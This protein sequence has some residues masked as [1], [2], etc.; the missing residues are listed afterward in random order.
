MTTI[1]IAQVL[2]LA[3]H[4]NDTYKSA[5]ADAGAS[6]ILAKHGV[7][8]SPLRI[9][10]FF[11][12]ILEETGDF[13]ALVE[14]LNY[15]VEGLMKTWPS[16]FPTAESAA[17]FAHKPEAI[18]NKV[19][20]DRAELGNDAPG[21]G[22]RYRGRGLLQITG[23]EA[24]RR[25][26]GKIG[27]DLVDNPD[28]AADPAHCLEIAAAEYATAGRMRNGVFM[29]CNDF[30]D[31]DEIETITRIVNGGLI[32]LAQRKQELVRCKAV[33]LPAAPQAEAVHSYMQRAAPAVAAA[34]RPY[35]KLRHEV[36]VSSR[37]SAARGARR[38]WDLADLCKAYAWPSGA[39]GAG[40]IAIVE[41]AGGYVDED[42]FAFCDGA[43]VPRPNIESVAVH[44]G[45]GNNPGLARGQ[46]DD[47]DIEV[48]MDIEVA[49]AAYSFATGQP[50]QIR[51]YWALNRPGGIADAVRK[52]TADGCDVCSI[53]W[54]ADEAIWRSWA[55]DGGTQYVDDMEQAAAAAVKA[56]MIVFAAAGD[57]NASDGGANRANA[58]LP[59]SSPSVVG[60][61]GTTKTA[62]N[63]VVWNNTPGN[64][65]GEGTGG[66]FSD[67]FPRP[68]W[69]VGAPTDTVA[70]NG[71][72]MRM[73]PD[74]AANAD[75]KT[76][77]N[78]I[79][80]DVED[81]F[82]G[83]S[84]VAPLYAGLFA[85]FGSRLGF[86]GDRLWSHPACFVD[87]TQ[88]ENG[89]YS[90]GPGPD[91]CTGLGV[92]IGSALATL[93]AAQPARGVAQV[94]VE[95]IVSAALAAFGPVALQPRL[96]DGFDPQAAVS[97]GQFIDQAYAMFLAD[98]GNLTPPPG[99]GF[100]ATHRLTAWVQMQDFVVGGTGPVFYG[101][102][103]QSLADPTR[104]VLALRGTERLVEW[105]DDATSVLRVPFK[106][107]TDC[108][109]VSYGFARIYETMR[110]VEAPAPGVAG[111]AAPRSL[112]HVG[113]FA[114][115]VAAHVRGGRPA[116]LARAADAG[117]A[118]VL[119]IVG[120]SLG[121]ALAT[122][123]ALDN[124]RSQGPQ[125]P[126]LY[127]FASPMVGDPAFASAVDRLGF[128]SWRIVNAQDWVPKLPSAF[129]GYA[130]V[131]RE[132]LYDSSGEVQP[133]EACFH[134]MATYLHLIDPTLPVSSG[135]SL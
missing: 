68:A 117:P 42:V 112:S 22:W 87:I 77:Y 72:A 33:W 107:Y 38:S 71:P 115:Q 102:I 51:M 48:T 53:S 18:A 80:H 85:A 111:R 4:A 120:H 110:L 95:T 17:P 36:A 119:D 118:S 135:C 105:F 116:S 90:A 121:S 44:P 46:N 128:T 28:L 30:A 126:V 94:P 114:A 69:Q 20:G 13:R 25:I 40:V 93:F 10:H 113:G 43:G 34:C 67:A 62:I 47:P 15:S 91:P 50:A 125:T 81:A 19:Y 7:A 65:T 6:A 60:C 100:P 70:P 89:L 84:A 82:G 21:D 76:G 49:A 39:T 14:N 98:P 59:A 32:N 122:L 129:F 92:P 132:Q 29:T 73:I 3:P 64:P 2:S 45:A 97:Y 54:G 86:V 1:T 133:N 63:E 131:Q 104:S 106:T 26:G 124:A 41:L 123:F 35:F 101:F 130:H 127:T 75:P 24:Y 11:A 134:A 96:V 16:R 103:A 88:G 52:A 61:G 23:K 56:G 27:V 55:S 31:L 79:V 108:G 74:V 66:G 99:P 8:A 12:Q 9:C 78:L 83:T 5:F 37:A 57:N 109:T 58:D